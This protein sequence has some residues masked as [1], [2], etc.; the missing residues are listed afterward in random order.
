MHSKIKMYPYTKDSVSFHHHIICTGLNNA[1]PN[2]PLNQDDGPF[3]IQCTNGIQGTKPPGQQWNII[4]DAV[5][6]IRDTGKSQLIISSTS[7]SYMM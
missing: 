7:R 1:Y 3:C 5:A 2:V 4:L 6:T